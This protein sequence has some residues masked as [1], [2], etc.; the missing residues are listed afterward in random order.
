MET[1]LS[2]IL[3]VAVVIAVFFYYTRNDQHGRP[4]GRSLQRAPAT[5]ASAIDPSS[6]LDSS[7]KSK[8]APKQ[9]KAKAPRKSVK[10]TVQEVG[11]KAGSL[12][13]GAS[14]TADA[15]DDLSPIAS[16]ALGATTTTKAPSGR[17]VSDML[18]P[19]AAAPVVLKISAS[20]KPARP[21]KPQQQRTEGTQETKRQ[22]QN[23]KK[24]E[25]A[26]VQREADEKERKVLLEKQRRTA[27]EARGEAAK[28]GLQPSQAPATNAWSAVRS[29]GTGAGATSTNNGQLLDTFDPEIVSTT[30]SSE[31]ATNGTAPTSDGTSNSGPWSNLPPEEEQMRLALEDS[32]DSWTPVA[33]KAKKQRKNKAVGDAAE[34][35]SDSGVTQAPAVQKV[36]KVA[37]R[38][39]ENVQPQSRFAALAEPV[40]HVGHPLDSDWSVA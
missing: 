24:A 5:N 30:S 32:T 14:S 26:K 25:E 7:A 35:G 12:V 21:T 31:A 34:E 19:H 15:D 36:Q 3:F 8:T 6:W 1:W 27:R 33:S 4:R 18:E 13:S 16:P 28:N 2:W 38:Q 40:P 17:D 23:R 9:A 39:P 10:K 29:S 11:N 22:R 37:V 20:D